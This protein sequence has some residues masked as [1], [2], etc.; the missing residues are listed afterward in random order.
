MSDNG[1]S[2]CNIITILIIFIILLWVQY[3]LMNPKRF[4][5]KIEEYQNIDDKE[6]KTSEEDE[7]KFYEEIWNADKSERKRSD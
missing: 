5:K 6:N 2:I 1:Q 4:L 7:K 3:Y